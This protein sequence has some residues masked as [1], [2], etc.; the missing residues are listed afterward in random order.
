MKDTNL[1]KRRV[2]IADDEESNRVCLTIVLEHE[3]W[4]VSQARDGKEALEQVLKLRPNLLLLD[5]QMPNLTGAE[6]YQHLQ[7]HGIELAVV[8]ISS[9]IELEKLASSLGIT[10]FIHKPFNIS[11]LIPTIQSAYEHSLKK[12][13]TSCLR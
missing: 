9:Y 1:G 5:Y 11:E 4:E 7:L 6:V 12:V 8:L 2:L 13:S 10:Y 3:G